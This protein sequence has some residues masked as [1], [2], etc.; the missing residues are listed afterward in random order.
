MRDMY[1]I[2]GLGALNIDYI[3][4]ENKAQSLNLS[5]KDIFRADFEPGIEEWIEDIQVIENEITTMGRDNFRIFCGGSAFNTIYALSFLNKNFKLG[6]IGIRGISEDNCDFAKKFEEARI[7]SQFVKYD[8]SQACGKSISYAPSQ[9]KKDRSLKT[10]APIA[11]SLGKY[12]EENRESI[13]EYLGQTRFIHITSIFDSGTRN[14]VNDLIKEAKKRN[15][16]LKISFDP[17]YEYV[18]RGPPYVEKLLSVADI[19]FLNNEEFKEFGRK[20]EDINRALN[21]F[22]MINSD[23]DSDGLLIVLKKYSE[24]CIFEKF[25]GQVY[26]KIYKN[27]PIS[28]FEDDTGA[29]DVFA[30]GF[31]ASQRLPLLRGE[32]TYGIKLGLNMVKRKLEMLGSLN[33]RKFQNEV[34]EL[35]TTV[36]AKEIVPANYSNPF[37]LETNNFNAHPQ[38]FIIHGHDKRSLICLKDILNR[39]G[40]CPITFEDIPKKGSLS[41][42]EILEGDFPKFSAFIAL[43]TPDDEGRK[44]GN[45]TLE[46]RARQ[47]VLIEAG[48][49]MISRRVQSLLINLGDVSIPSDFEGIHTVLAAEWSS[50][51]GLQVAKRLAEM[52]LD[53]DPSKAI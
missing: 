41:V 21:V 32:F 3:F 37:D 4:T 10:S 53:V 42:I 8:N 17:G 26:Q 1:D 2:I 47:N 51:V 6:F 48:Y 52:G 28:I 38:I 31:L 44:R 19:V 30:A 49:C 39:I 7:D 9:I 14:I 12:L 24:I 15:R 50:E 36:G 45:A 11:S 16:F 5:P 20:E 43:L 35:L 33:Y 46:Y 22:R 27:D 34:D 40:A 29:G 23:E 18:K 25:N 13:L